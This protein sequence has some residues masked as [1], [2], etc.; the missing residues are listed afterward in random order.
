MDELATLARPAPT[1]QRPLLGLTVLLVEDSRFASE[2]VRLL[3]MASGARIRR[4][5]CIASADR[6]LGTYAPGVAIVDL[7]LPDGPGTDLIARLHASPNRP[8]VILATSGVDRHAAE[9]DALAAGADGFLPKPIDSLAAFQQAILSRL[10]AS[11][12]PMG[13]RAVSNDTVTPDRLALAEDYASAARM[14]ADEAVP[15][16]F[17]AGFLRGLARTGNDTGL[18]REIGSLKAPSAELR[19]RLRSVVT[20]RTLERRVI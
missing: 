7:G 15:T 20:A 14:L 13:L 18:L 19:E 17:I 5:D 9:A 12:R 2:A 6:H 16:G 10:P 1:A 11:R 4:A 8:D 3:C